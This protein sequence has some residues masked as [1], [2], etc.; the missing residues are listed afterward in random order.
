[1]LASIKRKAKKFAKKSK[2]IL[3]TFK[4][5]CIFIFNIYLINLLS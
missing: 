3:K 4:D 1:M 5:L 2:K